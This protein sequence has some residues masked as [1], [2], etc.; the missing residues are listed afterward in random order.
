MLADDLE[1]QEEFQSHLKTDTEVSENNTSTTT[2]V[3]I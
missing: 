1:T 3:T 2:R